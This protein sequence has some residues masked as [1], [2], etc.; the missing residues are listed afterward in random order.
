MI[1][2][3]P[4]EEDPIRQGDIFF[5]LPMTN[6]E[7]D[8]IAVYDPAT[9]SYERANWEDISNKE[10]MTNLPLTPV[11]GIVASQDCDIERSPY[12]S[13]FVIHPYTKVNKGE[14][15][16]KKDIRSWMKTLITKGS[17]DNGKFFYLPENEKIGFTEKMAAVFQHVI[18]VPSEGL[19]SRKSSLRKGRLNQTGDEHFRESIAQYFRR[20]PYNEWYP[21]NKEEF[22]EYNIYRKGG[23]KPYPWQE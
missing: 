21:L 13:F 15:Y 16:S 11:W 12:I 19:L 7:W 3:F 1:Y 20:Y 6:I 9:S 22:K 23:I 5:P 18:Q 17:D 2:E 4:K 8:S 10:V 14:D